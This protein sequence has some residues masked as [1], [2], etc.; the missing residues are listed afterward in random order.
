MNLYELIK[1][2]LPK[3]SNYNYPMYGVKVR[4]ET[5]QEVRKI[6]E[7]LE[8]PEKKGT[9]DWFAIGYDKCIDDYK[10]VLEMVQENNEQ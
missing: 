3:E 7:S 5:I 6:L 9:S 8:L 1:E 4:D 10:E 2:R